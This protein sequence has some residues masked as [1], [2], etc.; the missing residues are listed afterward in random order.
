MLIATICVVKINQYAS[1]KVPGYIKVIVFLAWQL[2]FQVI[3]ILTIDI[4]DVRII[5]V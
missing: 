2:V 5:R 1:K 4:Y 3:S